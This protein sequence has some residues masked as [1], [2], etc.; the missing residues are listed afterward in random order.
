MLGIEHC[1]RITDEGLAEA[2]Q[3]FRKLLFLST[4]NCNRIGS[5]TIN[6]IAK[7]MSYIQDLYINNCDLIDD[8]LINVLTKSCARVRNS[9]LFCNQLTVISPNSYRAWA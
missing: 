1:V 9:A 8:N 4:D 3:W 7:R 6:A 2:A 5:L